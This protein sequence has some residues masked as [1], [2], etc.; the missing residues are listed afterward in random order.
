[1]LEF[2]LQILLIQ[3]HHYNIFLKNVIVPGHVVLEIFN[4]EHL[5]IN[6]TFGHALLLFY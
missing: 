4:V 2:S 1:M 6:D 5:S 3:T